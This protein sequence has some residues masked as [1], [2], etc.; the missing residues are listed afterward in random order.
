MPGLGTAAICHAGPKHLAIL[1][2]GSAVPQDTSWPS[3]LTCC[4]GQDI[5]S[6]WSPFPL[7]VHFQNSLS[8]L[9]LPLLTQCRNE[10]TSLP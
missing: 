7:E 9:G 1:T 4:E 10:T 3:A 8:Q 6:T 2:S 5:G